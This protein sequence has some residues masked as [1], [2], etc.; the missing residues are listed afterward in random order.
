MW[1]F[2]QCSINNPCAVRE[3]DYGQDPRP[4]LGR[5]FFT[6]ENGDVG[7]APFAAKA[8][9]KICIL[10]SCQVP[11]LLRPEGGPTDHIVVGNCYVSSII[12][13]AA[14]LGPLP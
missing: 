9:D 2:C 4:P 8:G 10:L 14:L 3:K 5:M 12:D 7:L 13:G 11:L 1:R 6:A